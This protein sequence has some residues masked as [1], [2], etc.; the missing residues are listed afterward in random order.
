MKAA[1]IALF[2]GMLGC[3]V[4]QPA[5]AADTAKYREKVLYSFGNFPDGEQPDAGVVDV[6]GTLYGTTIIG[7][8]SDN[9]M[10][11][12][13]DPNTGKEKM[14]YSFSD[15]ANP[16]GGLIDVK[17]ILYGTT[18]SGDYGAGAVFGL[19]VKTDALTTLYSFCGQQDCADGAYPDGGLIDVKGTLYGTTEGGGT[20]GCTGLGCGTVFS[21]DPGTGAEKVLYAFCGQQGCPDG[22]WP[23]AG[24]IDVKGTLYGAAANGGVPGC[25]ENAGCGTL[26]SIDLKTGAEKTLYTFCSAQNCADGA[27]PFAAMIEANG[28]LYGTTGQGGGTGCNGNG[29]GTVFSL[30]PKTGAETVLY[31]FQGGADGADPAAGLI[32]VKGALY[33]T[34]FLG[35][36]AGCGGDGCGTVFSLD[37]K[38]GAETVLY[39]FCSQDNCADGQAPVAPLLDV[40]GTLYGTTA[41]GGTYNF[42][43]VFVLQKKG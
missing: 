33:G 9:G 42:G 8:D 37:S 18:S 13:L 7:G 30:D 40:N 32:K 16:A 34:T 24:L 41:Y 39:A 23:A 25:N 10:V 4:L 3:A 20:T 19:D 15:A 22:R 5:S 11:F 31:A 38:T 43:T 29:C 2:A 6:K 36:G 26:F 1:F 14:L 27:N 12:S 35:G 28:I 21:L 17:G